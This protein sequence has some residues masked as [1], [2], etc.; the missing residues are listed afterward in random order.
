MTMDW[1]S[2]SLHSGTIPGVE[3]SPLNIGR[4]QVPQCSHAE[5]ARLR[6]QRKAR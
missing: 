1:L 6:L 5:N 4:S 2:E 3:R